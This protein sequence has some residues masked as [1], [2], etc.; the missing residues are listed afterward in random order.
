MRQGIIIGVSADKHDC[1]AGPFL[2]LGV[3]LLRG[4]LGER[5]TSNP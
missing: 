3:R 5:Q 2:D 1:L 4:L